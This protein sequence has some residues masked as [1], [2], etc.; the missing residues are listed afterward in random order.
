MLTVFSQVRPYPV[1]WWKERC[2]M[3]ILMNPLN[4]IINIIHNKN[5]INHVNHLIV[6]GIFH[7]NRLDD[8]ILLDHMH[9]PCVLN[10]KV[11]SHDE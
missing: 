11:K 5:G 2:V 4:D 7:Q 6:V 9:H 1:L 8:T 10:P 3:L